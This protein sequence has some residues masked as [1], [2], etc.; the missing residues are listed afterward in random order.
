MSTFQRTV[1]AVS[2]V[3][4]LF[5]VALMA[6]AMWRSR[7]NDVFPPIIG[8]CPD[9]WEAISHKGKGIIC[10]NI[11]GLGVCNAKDA[12]V[13]FSGPEWNQGKCPKARWARKCGLTWD[14]ILGPDS[15]ECR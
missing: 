5:V 2:V 1:T 8:A 6:I 14:G 9:Y 7:Y 15:N 4:F 10:K 12:E 11:H 3:V 13:D